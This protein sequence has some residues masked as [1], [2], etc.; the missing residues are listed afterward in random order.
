[1][2][3]MEQKFRTPTFVK[4]ITNTFFRPSNRKDMRML[5]EQIKKE[6]RK[7]R[8]G[9]KGFMSIDL[10]QIQKEGAAAREKNDTSTAMLETQF[11]RHVLESQRLVT[12]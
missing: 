1:M 12:Q 5:R 6:S 3:V 11:D 7:M 2:Q 9:H 4:K 10:D 8:N